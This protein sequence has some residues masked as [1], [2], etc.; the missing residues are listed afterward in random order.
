MRDS[1]AVA[2]E[3][4]ADVLGKLHG[5]V[6]VDLRQLE[7]AMEK[8]GAPWTPGRVPDWKPE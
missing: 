1:Y 6:D 4:F 7:D 8:A 5:L 3:Q 2:G